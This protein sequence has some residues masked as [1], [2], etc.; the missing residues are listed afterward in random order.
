VS[1]PADPAGD[2]TPIPTH[3]RG[4]ILRDDAGMFWVTCSCGWVSGARWNRDSAGRAWR[5][6]LVGTGQVDEIVNVVRRLGRFS[7][8]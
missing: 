5:T 8:G 3:A 7:N 2:S 1:Q 6:H 4:A